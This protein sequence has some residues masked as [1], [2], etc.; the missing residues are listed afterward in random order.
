MPICF[1]SFIDYQKVNPFYESLFYS[2]LTNLTF[3]DKYRKN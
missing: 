2:I 1:I 3:K